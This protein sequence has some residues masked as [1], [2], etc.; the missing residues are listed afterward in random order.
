MPL[1]ESIQELLR[2]TELTSR[3]RY[4]AARRLNLHGIFSQW[5][6]ALLAV[7]Q[8]VITLIPSLGIKTNLPTQYISFMEIFFGIL[9]LAYSLL[10]GMGNHVARS[11]HMH[12]CGLELGELARQL[13]QLSRANTSD[14][15]IYEEQVRKY[16][17]ALE[18]CE[19]HTRAD[20]LISRL[21]QYQP[22]EQFG[23]FSKKWY[24]RQKYRLEMYLLHLIQFVHYGAS[25]A[26]VTAWI[27][28]LVSH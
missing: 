21:E 4:H 10:L 15:K 12:K 2:R 5:T 23:L 7:G 14:P 8:I 3:A 16:Y 9:V 20:Y 22:E 17:S 13:H 25:I 6:L 11:I 26:L 27:W 1:L 18:K 24:L 19:N 28:L